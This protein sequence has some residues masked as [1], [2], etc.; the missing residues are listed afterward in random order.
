RD[1]AM[2]RAHESRLADEGTGRAGGRRDR[3][4][5]PNGRHA[6]GL[7]PQ[8]QPQTL[9]EVECKAECVIGDVARMQDRKR[10]SDNCAAKP[11]TAAMD[12]VI[13]STCTILKNIV[14]KS[15][16]VLSHQ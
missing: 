10:S 9:A 11:S 14:Q 1:H 12:N 3:G 5:D 4:S 7:G 16:E 8:A 6:G 2:S 15:Y 13:Q